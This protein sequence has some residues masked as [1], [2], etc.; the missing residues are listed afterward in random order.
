M[1]LTAADLAPPQGQRQSG[2][3]LKSILAVAYDYQDANGK[4]LFQVCRMEPKDFRQRRPDPNAF[5]GW[6]WNLK[7]VR[8]VPFLLPELISAVNDGRTIFIAEGEKDVIALVKQGFAAT[9]N[10]GG[11]G[12]WRDEFGAVFD[13]AKSVVIIADK[14][15]PGRTHAADVAAKLKTRVGSVKVIELPDQGTSP[16]KDAADFF[17]AAGT[18]EML[19]ALAEAAPEYVPKAEITPGTWFKRR[20]PKL[21]DKYGEPVYESTSGKRTQVRD[22]AEDFM[23]AT[24]GFDGMPETPTIFFPAEQRFYTYS[25]A[26]GIFEPKREE[27]IAARLSALYLE[28]VRACEDS[29][30]TSR[31]AFGM[32]DTSALAG[33]IRRA[34]GLLAVPDDYFTISFIE[35][36]PVAN[37]MLRIKDRALLEF[38]PSYRCRH[39]LAVEFKPEAVAPMFANKLLLPA[40]NSADIDLI[41]RWAGLALVG[42]NM[43]QKILLLTGTAGGGKSTLVTILN[44]IIGGGNVGMLRTE[45]LGDRFEIGRL[46]GKTLLYGS[47]VPDS[48]LTTE[49]A[50]RLKSLTGGD[51]MTAEFKNSNEAP[52][53][54]CRFNIIVTSNSRLTVCLEGDSDAWRRRL[55]IVNYD[56]PKPPVVIADLAERILAGEGPGVLNFMLDGLDAL[57]AANWDLRLNEAQQRRVDDLLLESDSHRVFVTECLIKDTTAPGLTKADVYAA[58]V[59]F[60][61]RRGWVAM[62][63]NRFG[64]LGAEAVA[65]VFG[66]AVRGDVMNSDGRQNDGWKSLRL[67][68]DRDTV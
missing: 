68:T 56:R 23:A 49:T 15:V 48:F 54:K 55:V 26:T 27:D 61:D 63:K 28:A 37:G 1:R 32:R 4:L 14:D 36:L 66:L 65:Q 31:L 19:N 45:L 44:G 35:L 34:K 24:L 11:A 18:S 52:Q 67:R 39:K 30:D 2:R 46:S 9:C 16:V 5:D 22:V 47:D 13:G 25:P 59:E 40:L 12:K 41:Q 33:I 42:I 43:S 60:C 57:M 20:F 62:N 7:G 21:A 17:A 58:F 8:Q 64:K 53:I 38:S 10:A 51:V 3:P 50:S 6:A 29:A